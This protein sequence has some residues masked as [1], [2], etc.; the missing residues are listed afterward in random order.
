M[1]GI[2]GHDHEWEFFLNHECKLGF[3]ASSLYLN[4]M[5]MIIVILCLL[6]VLLILILFHVIYFGLILLESLLWFEIGGGSD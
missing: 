2:F 6:F 5:L 3:L 4:V 1:Q